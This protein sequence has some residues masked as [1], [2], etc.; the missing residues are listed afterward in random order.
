MRGFSHVSFPSLTGESMDSRFRGNDKTP[1]VFVE[2]GI[3]KQAPLATARLGLESLWRNSLDQCDSV[4]SVVCPPLTCWPRSHHSFDLPFSF[5]L[6]YLA[7]DSS[8][9]RTSRSFCLPAF[10][11][12]RMISSREATGYRP[13]TRTARSLA[14]S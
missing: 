1:D 6:R 7:K 4:G 5:S 14:S 11:L 3:S 2:R 12:L 10:R 9:P 13:S 8:R